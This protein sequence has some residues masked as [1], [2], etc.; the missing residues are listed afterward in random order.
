MF[1]ARIART[2]A[3]LMTAASEADFSAVITR[4]RK[5]WITTS[6]ME[7]LVDGMS[8]VETDRRNR[9]RR[10]LAIMFCRDPRIVA[11]VED[12]IRRNDAPVEKQ[13]Q[14]HLLLMQLRD[15][16]RLTFA[17]LGGMDWKEFEQQSRHTRDA[18]R[19]LRGPR[20]H[21]QLL[22]QAGSDWTNAGESYFEAASFA[23]WLI[24]R[25][26]TRQPTS[27]ISLRGASLAHLDVSALETADTIGLSRRGSSETIAGA[28]DRLGSSALAQKRFVPADIDSIL[29]QWDLWRQIFA[30]LS[31]VAIIA[32]H[33]M[34]RFLAQHF[35]LAVRRR[36]RGDVIARIGEE[37]AP[38]RGEVVLVAQAASRSAVC[39]HIRALGGIA[40]DIHE[41]ARYW[42]RFADRLHT[43]YW[44]GLE[45]SSS[46]IECQPFP[47]AFAG[48]QIS[49][50]EPCRSDISRRNNLTGTFDA[51]FSDRRNARSPALKTLLIVGHPRCG[52]GYVAKVLNHLKVDVG[53]ERM[54]K[55]G[56]CSWIETVDDLTP[57]FPR[58]A[59]PLATFRAVIGY[60][61]D[62]R[63]AV[64][65][66][67][68][69]NIFA[70][71]F[72][73]RRFHIYR[74]F[75]IDIAARRTP[76]ERAIESYLLWMQLAERRNPRC[77][78]RVEHLGEDILK[79]GDVLV[80]AGIDIDPARVRAFATV[81]TDVNASATKFRLTKPELSSADYRAIAPDLADQLAAFCE[82]YGY[83]SPF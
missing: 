2:K 60:V 69:E 28:L 15:M 4:L 32:D 77:I 83:A 6:E 20:T 12:R 74:A 11:Y 25:I 30:P 64:P 41:I 61:R 36:C 79:H 48:R 9:T 54:R 53:H 23:F 5:S 44:S 51:L 46:L 81:P 70:R 59:L 22:A 29:D 35:G 80:E 24:N 3:L 31:S 62:P 73:F 49:Q 76:V 10:L 58:R 1:E 82:R 19:N 34:S 14:W 52:S 37:L 57:P 78:W 13:I 42:H 55:D 43:K 27:V 33:D 67:M 21:D 75:G 7:L 47:N 38:S 26:R 45:I 71:S 65:S 18:I 72:D 68:L 56:I 8:A 50:S 16:H 66:I 17:E 63:E 40:L 39:A